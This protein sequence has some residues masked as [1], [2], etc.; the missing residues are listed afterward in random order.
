MTTQ[1]EWLAGAGQRRAEPLRED[2]PGDVGDRLI[3]A[4]RAKCAAELRRLMDA[5]DAANQGPCPADPCPL[6]TVLEGMH[7][8]ARDWEA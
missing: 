8:L 6:C 5:A 4:T 2:R 1:E 3:A 7:S